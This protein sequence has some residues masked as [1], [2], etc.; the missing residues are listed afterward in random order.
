MKP[1]AIE[2]CDNTC[3]GS[4]TSLEH[5][6][7]TLPERTTT[8][9]MAELFKALGDP[10]RVRLI[11]ALSRQE[12]CV[13]DLS[14]ILDMGQSAVSHQ[15]RYLRNL[16]IVKRRKEGKTVYYSLNDAHVEQIF[17]QTHEHIRHE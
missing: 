2:E 4:E 15:L 17:L 6:R 1:A 10:T 12:L 13:H 16:R 14:T 8:D 3:N 5:I 9:K 7:L 11:Y